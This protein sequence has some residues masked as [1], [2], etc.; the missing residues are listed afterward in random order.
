MKHTLLVADDSQTVQRI[1]E[2]ACADADVDVVAVADGELAIAQIADHPPDIVLA[3]IAMPRRSGYD[4]AAFVKG[5]ADLAHIPVVLMAGMFETADDSRAREVGCD[6]VLVKPLKPLHVIERV[7]YWL[8]VNGSAAGANGSGAAAIATAPVPFELPDTFEGYQLDEKVGAS[9]LVS[10]GDTAI[11]HAD[12]AG[13]SHEVSVPPAPAPRFEPPPEIPLVDHIAT[14]ETTVP[15]SASLEAAAAPSA[16]AAAT[17]VSLDEADGALL[18]ELQHYGLPVDVEEDLDAL[19]AY[20]PDDVAGAMSW[21]EEAA[22]PT[23]PAGRRAT[24][25]A[26]LRAGVKPAAPSQLNREQS[27]TVD[28][29][30]EVPSSNLSPEVPA[31][32]DVPTAPVTPIVPVV[33]TAP[34]G[35][36]AEA[37]PVVAPPLASSTEEYFS[38]LDA[39]FK[40]LEHIGDTRGARTARAGDVGHAAS[41]AEPVPTLQELLSRLPDSAKSLLSAAPPP[42]P[43]PSPESTVVHPTETTAMAAGVTADLEPSK[44]YDPLM[45][46]FDPAPREPFV[47]GSYSVVQ[48]IAAQVLEQLAQRDDLLD[49]L[50]RRIVLFERRYLD[51]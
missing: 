3:D 28:A 34:R 15:A 46:E 48:A 14:A 25:P 17:P 29:S 45:T 40:S 2:M 9:T 30:T 12:A 5:R 32:A 1:V 4:V 22:R 37:A 13:R 43:E 49:E 36:V 19:E 44:S 8:H 18:Q 42:A 35:P 39:A 10:E 23:P 20:Q 51:R 41:G 7:K 38:R 31:V 6:E 16:P 50:A 27:M 11:G 26:G 33:S 47:E 24:P 21:V